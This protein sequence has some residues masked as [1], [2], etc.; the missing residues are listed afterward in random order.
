MNPD[1][2]MAEELRRD[3]DANLFMV[4]GE[5]DVKVDRGRRRA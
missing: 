1:L 2:H 3:K 4:I 5:P